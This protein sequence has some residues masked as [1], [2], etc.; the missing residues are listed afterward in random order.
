[1]SFIKKNFSLPV[2]WE[3]INRLADGKW[4]VFADKAGIPQST[5]KQWL[6]EIAEPKRDNL[7]KLLNFTSLKEKDF[8]PGEEKESISVGESQAIYGIPDK[9][10]LHRSIDTIL[11]SKDRD[12]IQALDMNIKVFLNK[13]IDKKICEDEIVKL[14]NQMNILQNKVNL[15]IKED[16]EK[17]KEVSE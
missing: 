8:Y 11:A 12:T 10:E 4:S 15:F 1:M 17:K 6:D 13:V 14:K 3:A 9:K 16:R 5:F 2:L 7:K